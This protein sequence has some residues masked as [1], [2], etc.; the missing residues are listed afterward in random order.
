MVESLTRTQ[1]ALAATF[2]ASRRS[3]QRSKN[4]NETNPALNAVRR[5]M[6]TRLR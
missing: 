1:P 4:L 2:A 6:P 3:R 5:T